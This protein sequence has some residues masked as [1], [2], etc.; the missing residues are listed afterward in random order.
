MRKGASLP[1]ALLPY[2]CCKSRRARSTK[3]SESFENCFLTR[4]QAQTYRNT[5]HQHAAPVQPKV[6][7]ML[8]SIS[9]F[10][11][12]LSGPIGCS[13]SRQLVADEEFLQ[14]LKPEHGGEPQQGDNK[15]LTSWSC[16]H[17]QPCTWPSDPEACL[18][19]TH[20]CPKQSKSFAWCVEL[21]VHRRVHD[22]PLLSWANDRGTHNHMSSGAIWFGWFSDLMIS[23]CS[24][25]ST[26]T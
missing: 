10:L 9:T 6:C 26:L 8:A 19:R 3:I 22:L 2:C 24:S 16:C 17:T 1:L 25:L 7:F 20:T 14:K 15:G 13:S 4:V 5:S 23:F 21:P 18:Q 11:L 12:K